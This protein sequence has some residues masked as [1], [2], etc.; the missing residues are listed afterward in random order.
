MT[1]SLNDRY[2]VHRNRFVKDFLFSG[3]VAE[4]TQVINGKRHVEFADQVICQG[5][6]LIALSTE[7]AI[8]KKSGADSRETI[9]Y[10]SS[11]LESFDGLEDSAAQRYGGSGVG[12]GFFVRDN[13]VGSGDPR[14]LGKFDLCKSDWQTTKL[15]S[16]ENDSP[17][18]D[19]ILGLMYGLYAVKYFANESTLNEKAETI[20]LRVYEYAKRN[21]FHLKLPNGK[22]TRRGSEMQ[23]MASLAH[24]L[25]KKI[26]GKD[27]FNSSKV[28]LGGII[29]IGLNGIAAFWDSGESAKLLYAA[30]GESISIPLLGSWE[31]DINAFSVHMILM[32]LCSST[33]WSQEELERVSK[34]SNHQFSI[35]LYCLYNRKAPLKVKEA[36]MYGILDSCAPQEPSSSAKVSS[37]WNK[38]DRWQRCLDLFKGS[39]SSQPN[40]IIYNG[41][42]W[43]AF[44][45]ACQLLFAA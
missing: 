9:G 33:V 18:V 24:G 34:R 16:V 20:S 36:E 30:T 23:L 37:G 41:L 19:Q 3:L 10:I 31:I 15:H 39:N 14:L 26:T 21:H 29:D 4:A 27:L 25:N 35:I 42:D 1:A 7:C 45:N 6:A 11:I 44:H 12:S 22:P 38:D 40:P 17:S 8:L 43:L 13:I 5:M 32:S 2:F 28:Q